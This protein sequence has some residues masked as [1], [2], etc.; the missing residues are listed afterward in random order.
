M[1][2]KTNKLNLTD[3]FN[4]ARKDNPKLTYDRIYKEMGVDMNSD[5]P[6]V[7]KEA[8]DLWLKKYGY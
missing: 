1:N 4:N 3:R 7:Y 2:N 8:E 6:D 5:D